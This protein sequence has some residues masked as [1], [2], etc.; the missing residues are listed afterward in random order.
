MPSM[1]KKKSERQASETKEDT[2]AAIKE[3]T[4]SDPEGECEERTMMLTTRREI[5][6][7]MKKSKENIPE[8]GDAPN[9]GGRFCCCSF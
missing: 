5:E 7:A 1:P 2:K 8:H 4:V 3:V 6:T 9:R